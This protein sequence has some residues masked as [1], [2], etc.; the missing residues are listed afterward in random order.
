MFHK[1]EGLLT[2]GT[3]IDCNPGKGFT[4][5]SWEPKQPEG[6]GGEGE[7]GGATECEGCKRGHDH[8]QMIYNVRA[9]AEWAEFRLWFAEHAVEDG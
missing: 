3:L 1:A 8:L 6:G 2:T 4:G 7:C 5:I 9:P